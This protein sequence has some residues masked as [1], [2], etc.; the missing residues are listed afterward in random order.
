MQEKVSFSPATESDTGLLLR[1]IKDL[2]VYEERLD[3]VTATEEDLRDCLFVRRIAEAQFILVN[4]VEVGYVFYHYKYSTF[5]GKPGIYLE[6]LFVQPEYRGRGCGKK[7]LQ[8]VAALAVERGCGMVEW[9]CL[10]WNRP[11][12]DFYLS[13]GAEPRAEW[14]PYRLSGGGLRKLAGTEAAE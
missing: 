2:A 4:G 6:D 8:R 14:V 3:Q 5:L 13:L 7:L 11:S 10:D 1:F 9:H 12:I